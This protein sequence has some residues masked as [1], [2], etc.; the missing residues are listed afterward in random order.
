MIA[1]LTNNGM[2]FLGFP[3]GQHPVHFAGS[4]ERDRSSFMP[5]TFDGPMRLGSLSLA[6]KLTDHTLTNFTLDNKPV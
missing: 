1:N 4:S 6:E 3:E 5:D 2:Y